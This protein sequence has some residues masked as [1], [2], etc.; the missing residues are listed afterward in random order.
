[1]D[2]PN[3]H[4]YNPDE[5]TVCW[6][7]DKPL[8]K[9]QP[10]KKRQPSQQQWLYILI[11]VMVILMLVNMCGLPQLLSPQSG[12]AAPSGMIVPYPVPGV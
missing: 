7:C 10:V 2:C 5:R 9:P 3:C 11:G 1:M 4:T 12:G 8:P 6:R